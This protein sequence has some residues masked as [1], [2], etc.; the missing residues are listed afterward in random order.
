M[1]R[2]IIYK[3]K[4]YRRKKEIVKSIKKER[5]IGVIR[6]FLLLSYHVILMLRI[7]MEIG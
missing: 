3:L 6:S 4:L 2:N 5:M 1:Y 7:V